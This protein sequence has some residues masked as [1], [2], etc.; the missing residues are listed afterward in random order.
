[1]NLTNEHVV[2][3]L[4]SVTCP[5]CHQQQIPDLYSALKFDN[6]NYTATCLCTDINCN[7]VFNVHYN[8]ISKAIANEQSGRC[9]MVVFKPCI[10]DLSP[11]FCKIYNEAYAA[12][13]MDLMEITGVGYR[14]A[15]EFLI[16]DYLISAN[17]DQENTI[18]S[19]FLGNCIKE[20]ISEQRIKDVAN[21][22]VWLGNDKTHYIRKWE[23][24]DVSHLKSIIDLCLH[25]IEAEIATRQLL[26][27]MPA[28]K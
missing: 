24:K 14:K 12:E 6:G 23:E 28:F 5:Y 20:D 15:L 22:A 10:D 4:K 2:I 18:K 11:M 19:K 3:D 26:D 16:K 8:S 7:M 1:M 9:K 17:P 27:D 25:W 13:Q 21:R